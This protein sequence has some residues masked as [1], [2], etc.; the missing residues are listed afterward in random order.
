MR[1]RFYDDVQGE[2]IHF[3]TAKEVKEYASKMANDLNQ[4]YE[5]TDSDYLQPPRTVK[6]ATDILSI[7]DIYRVR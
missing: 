6:E 3:K 1:Y 7:V 5:T 4:G 2:D